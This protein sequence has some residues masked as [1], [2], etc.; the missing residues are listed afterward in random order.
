MVNFNGGSDKVPFYEIFEFTR[1]NITHVL[2]Y[3]GLMNTYESCEIESM[4]K[5]IFLHGDEQEVY[6]KEERDFIKSVGDIYIYK[7]FYKRTKRGVIP[8]RIIAA[9]ISD[10]NEVKIPL[11]FMKEI[12]KAVSGFNIFFLNTGFN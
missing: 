9:E 4:D 12:N 7:E 6:N 10:T 2:E 8:C 11:F 5:F 3:M 1:E